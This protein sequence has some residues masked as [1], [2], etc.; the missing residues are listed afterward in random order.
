VE[1]G[2]GV[3]L[4]AFVSTKRRKGKSQFF[5]LKKKPH[6]RW[7]THVGQEMSAPARHHTDRDRKRHAVEE[8][9]RRN[10]RKKKL[11][12]LEQELERYKQNEFDVIEQREKIAELRETIRE[13]EETIVELED[14]VSEMQEGVTELQEEVAFWKW[15]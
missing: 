1:E 15:Q 6:F 12:E 4:C 2:A 13:I 8:R 14:E 5:V 9:Q 3:V 10:K 7:Q 11:K